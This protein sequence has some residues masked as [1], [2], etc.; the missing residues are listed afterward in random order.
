MGK[1]SPEVPQPETMQLQV[2]VELVPQLGSSAV[3]WRGGPSC[4]P[5]PWPCQ[6]VVHQHNEEGS[7]EERKGNSFA[8]YSG[9]VSA[10]PQG[11]QDLPYLL[12]HMPTP[13]H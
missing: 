1:T 7:L 4:P 5:T 8:F 2:E 6:L 13:H 3:Q 10:F 11:L 9:C 12:E